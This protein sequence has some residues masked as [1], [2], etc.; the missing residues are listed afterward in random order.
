MMWHRLSG[1]KLLELYVEQLHIQIFV[2]IIT[3]NKNDAFFFLPL[4]LNLFP[5]SKISYEGSSY[6][7]FLKHI[8]QELL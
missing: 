4:V 5:H 2:S 1:T 6:P 8:F 3:E 7:C